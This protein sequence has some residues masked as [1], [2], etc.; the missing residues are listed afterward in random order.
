MQVN[1]PDYLG[2]SLGKQCPFHVEDIMNISVIL[3]FPKL[4]RTFVPYSNVG[5]LP[6][7]E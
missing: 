4:V 3:H 2:Q 6:E 5:F 7:H 1:A